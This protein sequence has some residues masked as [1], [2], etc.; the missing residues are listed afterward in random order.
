[1]A[2]GINKLSA[3]AVQKAKDPGYYGDGGG[4]W[5]QVSKL[6]GKSWVFRYTRNGKTRDM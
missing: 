2:R 4:L 5:L 1:M 3:F 6:G